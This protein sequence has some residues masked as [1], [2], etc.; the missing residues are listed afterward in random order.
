MVP[1][2]SNASGNNDDLNDRLDFFIQLAIK[3]ESAVIYAFGQHWIDQHGA[4]QYFHE[5]G[6]LKNCGEAA[7]K[8]MGSS[9]TN[10]QV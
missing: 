6:S 7:Q 5:S 8:Q 9:Q 1:L 3:D 10:S 2:P 4:D